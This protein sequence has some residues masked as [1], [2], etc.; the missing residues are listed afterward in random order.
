MKDRSN[1]TSSSRRGYPPVSPSTP[2]LE[3]PTTQAPAMYA[4]PKAN[5]SNASGRSGTLGVGYGSGLDMEDVRL[6]AMAAVG[7]D[8]P[9]LN[10]KSS[11][12]DG[13]PVHYL[14][15]DMPPPQKD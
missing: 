10:H 2:I 8:V 15:P 4:N 13:R 11:F 3:Q 12:G 9:S 6:A 5:Y 1:S 14:I 7:L